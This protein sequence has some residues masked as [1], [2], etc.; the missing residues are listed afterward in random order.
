M[1]LLIAFSSSMYWNLKWFFFSY[2]NKVF[3]LEI[4]AV[5]SFRFTMMV[6]EILSGCAAKFGLEL[7]RF[8]RCSDVNIL[9]I[10]NTKTRQSGFCLLHAHIF[11]S[12]I[13]R[14]CDQVM[15]N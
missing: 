11:S 1:Q 5:F 10:I 3:F 7:I 12:L 14:V 13:K 2:G 8:P 6:L 4:R 9:Q 15:R